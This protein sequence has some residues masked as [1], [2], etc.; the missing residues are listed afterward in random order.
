[1]VVKC[2]TREELL[3][4]V[5]GYY[6]GTLDRFGPTFRGVDWNSQESQLLRFAQLQRLVDPDPDATVLDFGC[7]YG[8]LAHFL[9]QHGHRGGYHGVDL[10]A[11]MISA[12]RD[13][14]TSLSRCRFSQAA[15]PGEQA[16]YVLASGVFNVK[17]DSSVAVW[18]Q[19]V[20]ET[21]YGMRDLARHGVAFNMLTSYSDQDRRRPHLFYAD[22]SEILR[23]CLTR[24]SPRAALFHDYGLYEFTV[25][26]RL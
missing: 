20:E 18:R 4:Q 8:A 17:Q 21:L 3:E 14:T 11:R 15:A 6:E 26:V 10:S 13:E 12:A 25:H 5:R 22:P 19:H 23:F 2:M 1:M 16:D 24:L 9:R 7:G